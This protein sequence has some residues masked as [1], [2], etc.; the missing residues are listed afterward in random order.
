[1]KLTILGCS[2]ST[3]APDNPASGYLVQVDNAP[4]VMLDCGPGV[5][6]KVQE[7]ANPAE[8]HVALSHLHADHCL[9]VP[10]LMVWRRYHPVAPSA[11]RN[12]LVGPADTVNH[13]GP[14]SLEGEDDYSDSFAFTPWTA[15]VPH[16]VDRVQ[17]T[18]YPVIHPVET[19]G[20]RVTEATTGKTIAYSGD[21]A[22]TDSLI[23][24]ARDADLFLCEATWGD[25]SLGKPADMHMSGAEAGL[26]ASRAGAKK[27]VLIHIPP[28]ADPEAAL[29][30]A[31]ENFDGEVIVGESGM[32]FQ[33]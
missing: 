8:L 19:Y 11:G 9:D 4:G 17:I 21:S 28:W 14:L 12:Q 1:M 25:S 24:C 18:P 10:S 7:F 23:E 31:Q 2:G 3:G 15:R 27:L 16:I 20:L 30:S 29:R 33:L 26:I 13:L 5:L 6:A 22:Y 32:E